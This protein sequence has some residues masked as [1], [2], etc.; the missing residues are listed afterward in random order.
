MNRNVSKPISRRSVLFSALG[1]CALAAGPKRSYALGNG[2]SD[3][4]MDV[5]LS[6]PEAYIRSVD[7]SGAGWNRYV[8]GPNGECQFAGSY[9]TYELAEASCSSTQEDERGISRILRDIAVWVGNKL[10]GYIRVALKRVGNL[11]IDEIISAGGHYLLQQTGRNLLG[12]PYVSTYRF[13]CD[14]YPRHSG[15]YHRCTS[16]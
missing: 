13:S 3:N 12:K 16:A 7:E 15:E 9:P 14:V 5:D 6:S 1:V 4:F 11:I 10:L 2:E 8:L